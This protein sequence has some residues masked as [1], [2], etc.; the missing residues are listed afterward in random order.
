MRDGDGYLAMLNYATG[1]F[2]FTV[3]YVDY[4]IEDTLAP[5][6]TN[7]V[8]LSPSFKIGDK[9]LIVTE[10]RMDEYDAGGIDNNTAA[11]EA[12]FMF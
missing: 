8:T 6:E 4:A 2:G 7:S 11:V 12:L 5:I 3:R 9:L 10:Y 1:I